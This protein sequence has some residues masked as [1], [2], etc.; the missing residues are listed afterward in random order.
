MKTNSNLQLQLQERL[1]KEPILK[2]NLDDVR[3]AVN[4][5]TVILAGSVND[6]L[7][8]KL[9]HKVASEMNGVNRVVSTLLVEPEKQH[10][11]G[12]QID[13]SKGSM[14]VSF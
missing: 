10:R 9:I 7:Q 3:I 4:G 1:E 13:W 6:E 8:K 12:V 14:A 11:V 5:G 2:Y